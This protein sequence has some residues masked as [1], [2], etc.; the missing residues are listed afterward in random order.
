M[1]LR[2]DPWF[3]ERCQLEAEE[4]EFVCGCVTINE[5]GWGAYYKKVLYF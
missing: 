3:K 2:V 5:R 1:Q 4:F